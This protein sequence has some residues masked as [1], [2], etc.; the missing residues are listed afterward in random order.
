MC[1]LICFVELE[2]LVGLDNTTNLC[3]KA[4]NHF[5][6]TLAVNWKCA[7]RGSALL[8]AVVGKSLDVANWE[9]AEEENYSCRKVDLLEPL[10]FQLAHLID[11]MN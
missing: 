5:D 11:S 3:I 8:A 6:D 1:F 9:T 10:S 7:A 4:L 2:A